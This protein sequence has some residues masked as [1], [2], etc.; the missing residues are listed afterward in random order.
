MFQPERS[1]VESTCF[2]TKQWSVKSSCCIL[3]VSL[4]YN[5]L[6]GGGEGGKHGADG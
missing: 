1:I 5:S 4:A 3:A 2:G 6:V